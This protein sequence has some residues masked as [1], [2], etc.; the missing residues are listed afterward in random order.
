MTFPDTLALFLWRDLA[1]ALCAAA[2]LV[3]LTPRRAHRADP[4]PGGAADGPLNAARAD[5]AH[6]RSRPG[7]DALRA[8]RVRSRAILSDGQA[9][10]AARLQGY[11]DVR[12]LRLAPGIGLCSILTLAHR[13]R[14][15]AWA[16]FAAIRRERLDF[17]L[18][19]RSHWPV[20]AVELR[21]AGSSRNPDPTVRL[22]CELALLPLVE[23]EPG[24]RWDAVAEALDAATG[25]PHRIGLVAV[26]DVGRP[27]DP[28]PPIRSAS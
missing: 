18:T 25:R 8:C 19:D 11:C 16:A 13:D 20:C 2:A 10:L 1:I 17:V 14:A 12:D 21:A 24:W 23:V 22:A 26:A 9:A 4:P 7:R 28:A 15:T 6:E 5:A 3:S 27:S